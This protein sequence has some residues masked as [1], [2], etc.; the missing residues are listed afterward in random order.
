MIHNMIRF[1][2]CLVIPGFLLANYTWAEVIINEIHYD[3]DDQTE[4]VE[5]VELHNS[6]P[7]AADLSG[8]YFSSGIEYQFPAGTSLSANGYL[9]V[10]QNKEAVQNRFRVTSSRVYGPFQGR[11]DNDGESIELRNANGQRV[12]EVEYRL[13]FPWPTAGDLIPET[14]SSNSIQ[15][16]H[17]DFDND[18]PGSWRSA[19]P[20]PGRRNSV[21]ANTLPPHIDQ[22]NHSPQQP[23]SGEPV[24][25]TAHVSDPDGVTVVK[26]LYQ[27]VDPGDYIALDAPHYETDWQELAMHDDGLNG[28]R[29]AGDMIYSVLIPA[30]FQKHRRLMRYRIF[31]ADSTGNS[32]TVPYA[33]DPQPNFAYFIYD[34]VPPWTG[35]VR[36]G[37]TP[38][39]TYSSEL[40]SSLPVY[41]LIS[42]REEVE[43]ATWLDRN[44]SNEYHYI[45]TL[46]YNGV[47]YDH[48]RFRARGGTWRYAMGKNMWKFNMNR[49][50][51]FQAYDNYGV[52]YATRWDKVNLGANIQ[53]G[54]YLNRGEQG[55]F[56][57]VGF[58]LFNLAGM[59]APHTNFV[60]F[61]IID[62]EHEDGEQ[63]AAH[64]PLTS[65]GTQYDGDFWGL[66]LAVEQVDGRFLDEHGLPDGNLY[67]MENYTGEIRNQSP[68]G[69]SDGSDLRDFMRG[70]SQRNPSEN[71]WRENIDEMRYYNYRSIVEGIH[72]YDIAYGKNYYYYLNPETNEWFHIPWDLDLT[73]GDNMHGD[74]ED[75]FKR[76]GIL[77][78]TSFNIEYQN[79]MRE[80][81]DLLYNPDQTGQLI[82]EYASFIHTPNGESFVDADRAMWDYHWVMSSAA[83]QRGLNNP[84]KSGQGLFYRLAP[85]RDFAGMLKIMKNYVLSRGNWIDQ[86]ILQNDRDVP[87][88]PVITPLT[89]DFKIDNL[90]FETS[91][92]SDP[93]GDAF[94]AMKWR[95]AEVEPFSKPYLYDAPLPSETIVLVQ[96]GTSWRYFK[97]RQEPS[98][99]GDAWRQMEF[100]DSDWLRGITPIGYGRTLSEPL[101]MTCAEAIPLCI[102]V[103]PFRSKT[104]AQSITCTHPFSL[105]MA[106]I[107]GSTV[108]MS[109][110]HM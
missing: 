36:P 47:V 54:D 21:Y 66:Y 89:S 106:S 5:F 75:P 105:M 53:Q 94:S 3:P 55:M 50:H 78:N 69:V 25:I 88:T 42:S 79:R 104:S 100:D 72:H 20:T 40:L 61:R 48:V 14:G 33:D 27:I 10:A 85:S 86:R 76:A 98:E 44:T 64:P 22:V 56:E 108:C 11:L 70:Y 9:V 74:G 87:H 65:R 99:P 67:K 91:D 1:M 102:C 4:W 18:L 43:R 77:R 32:L 38:E 46:V 35:A 84:Q 28:D 92:F 95:I 96:P 8:W 30:E 29:I 19:E 93:N 62:E 59:E 110:R 57:S 80:I 81:R 103:K 90:K 71:W 7:E 82:H 37:Q 101:S 97:G 15:L 2:S 73:W 83:A 60:H 63:N 45:G 109:N 34:G 24:L 39:V 52:P 107:C 12:D 31:T 17:P 6:G 26:L 58:K 49:G 68:Y 51:A 13:G 23:K 41:H 16:V